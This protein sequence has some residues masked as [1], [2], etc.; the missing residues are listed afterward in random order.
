MQRSKLLAVEDEKRFVQ[1]LVQ[2]VVTSVDSDTKFNDSILLFNIAEDYDGVLDV[3]S[4]ELGACI[5][6]HSANAGSDVLQI[7]KSILDHYQN[8]SIRLDRKR[9]ETL[10]KLIKL[11]E[12]L[13]WI[14]AGKLD[15]ALVVS[16]CFV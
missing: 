6:Q 12:A 7:A 16:P 4:N 1:S 8:N 5:S 11:N 15:D 3:L 10:N 9:T 14:D 2:T 13:A